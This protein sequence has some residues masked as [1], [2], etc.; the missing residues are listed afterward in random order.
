MTSIYFAMH[1][2]LHIFADTTSARTRFSLSR[3][4]VH[5]LA[6]AFVLLAAMVA[7]APNRIY[8]ENKV[9][10]QFN[11]S[12]TFPSNKVYTVLSGRK[13]QMYANTSDNKLVDVDKNNTSITTT[14]YY[15]FVFVQGTG[16]N[17]SNYYLYN[18]GREQFATDVISNNSKST[19]YLR[20]NDVNPIYVWGN[21]NTD[22]TYPYVLSF[23][24]NIDGNTQITIDK[25]NNTN[26]LFEIY[27]NG[28]WTTDW[29]NIQPHYCEA[30]TE[31]P[32][33]TFTDAELTAAQQFLSGSYNSTTF[34][35]QSS[36]ITLNT[37]VYTIQSEDGYFLVAT[38]TGFSWPTTAPTD[39]SGQFVFFQNPNNT[40]DV[41]LYSVGQKKFVSISGSTLGEFSASDKLHLFTTADA[42]G[43]GFAF[44]TSDTWTGGS[45]LTASNGSTIILSTTT[46]PA[47]ANRFKLNAVASTATSYDKSAAQTAF[48]NYF[49]EYNRTYYKGQDITTSKGATTDGK[50][51]TLKNKDDKYLSASSSGLTTSATATTSNEQFLFFQNPAAADGTEEVYL[52]S[53][54]QQ[55]FVTSAGAPTATTNA[56]GTGNQLF[57]YTASGATTSDNKPYLA[58]AF[59]SDWD[60]ATKLGSTLNLDYRF[61]VKEVAASALSTTMEN[62]TGFAKVVYTGAYELSSLEEMGL[63]SKK[64]YY[65]YNGDYSVMANNGNALDRYSRTSSNYN[66]ETNTVATYFAFVT[67]AFNTDKLY[68]YHISTRKAANKS[69]KLVV[70]SENVNQ[71]YIY[72]T[73][74]PDFPFALSF[75]PE[76]N[77]TDAV[78]IQA[79]S[80]N[81]DISND[82]VPSIHNRLNYIEISYTN[83]TE[84]YARNILFG[85]SLKTTLSDI[86]R[87]YDGVY[88][89][90]GARAALR[91]DDAETKLITASN[92][93]NTDGPLLTDSTNK[94]HQFVFFPDHDDD[95]KVYLYN[96]QAEKFVNKSGNLST[97]EP[98][99]IYIFYTN[100]STYPY[101]FSF[102][103]SPT[104]G[105]TSISQYTDNYVIN[106][107]QS[108]GININYHSAY[109]A[110]NCF[111]INK[112]YGAYYNKNF[113]QKIL[114]DSYGDPVDFSTL[115][116][117]TNSV[118][119][120]LK[121][122]NGAYLSASG[123]SVAS[124]STT[125]T[126]SDAN[127]QFVFYKDPSNESIIYLYSVGRG[128]FVA[129]DGTYSSTPAALTFYQTSD[130][131]SYS[132]A[133]GLNSTWTTSVVGNS[134]VSVIKSTRFQAEKVETPSEQWEENEPATLLSG[135]YQRATLA[136]ANISVNK[137]YIITSD[138]NNSGYH[139][140]LDGS[141]TSM[142]GY[143][144]QNE[145]LLED[146][147][148]QP[149][150]KFAFV[151]DPQDESK[152]YLL[153]YVSGKAIDKDGNFTNDKSA[154]VTYQQ[155]YLYATNNYKY[156]LAFSFSPTWG[157]TDAVYLD[158]NYNGF[159]A[160]KLVSTDASIGSPK[161]FRIEEVDDATTYNLTLGRAALKGWMTTEFH[162]EGVQRTGL[163]HKKETEP[164]TRYQDASEVH[165][166]YYVD[167][168]RS[169]YNDGTK[170]VEKTLIFTI[171]TQNY[172]VGG[173]NLEPRGYFR[174]YDYRTDSIVPGGNLTAY[175]TG[176]SVKYDIN[177]RPLGYFST[178]N[179]NNPNIKTIGVYY[180]IPDSADYEN[181][182]GDIIA[183]DVSRYIDYNTVKD[184]D[185]NIAVHS[186]NFEHEPTL[187]IRYIYH[188]LPAK[189]LA[190]ELMDKLLTT[191][192]GHADTRWNKG[193]LLFGA[194]DGNSTMNLRADL[195]SL[196]RY[197][198]YPLTSDAY[199]TKHVYYN[200]TGHEFLDADF[201]T[202]EP[203]NATGVEWRVYN[204]DKSYYRT[205]Y[206]GSDLS[207]NIRVNSGNG[208][209]IDVETRGL[210]G[211]GWTKVDDS[212]TGTI[213]DNPITIGSTCYIVGYLTNGNNKCPF[214]NTR[215]DITDNNP[216]SSDQIISGNLTDRTES[217]FT[218][219]YGTTVANFQF[220]DENS[221]LTGIYPADQSDED[222]ISPIPSPFSW[223]QYS[224]VYYKLREFSKL[225]YHLAWTGLDEVKRNYYPL[226]GDFALYKR[227]GATQHD[228]TYYKS[229]G[230]QNGYFLFTDASDE[231]RVIATQDFQ[232]KFCTGS[233]LLITAWVSNN[234]A[235]RGS[236]G[237]LY[238]PPELR[239]NLLGVKKDDQNED[240]STTQLV[241]ICSG[242]F[243]NNIDDYSS[244]ETGTW[245]QVYGVLTIPAELNVSQFT[246]FRIAI[247]N[248]CGGATGADYAIDDIEVYQQNAKLTVIQI[249]AL[250]DD[251]TNTNEVKIK[252]KGNFDALRSVTNTNTEMGEQTVFYRFC[253]T[254]GQAVTGLDYDGD[255]KADEYGSATVPVAYSADAAQV[256]GTARFEKGIDGQWDLVLVNR[257]FTLD[258]STTYYVSLCLDAP[259]YDSNGNITAHK[260]SDDWGT[261][262][263]VC[264]TYSSNFQ[265]VEQQIQIAGTSGNSTSVSVPCGSST[266]TAYNGIAVTL[267]APDKVNGGQTILSGD[268]LKFFWFAGTKEEYNNLKETINETDVYLKNAVTAYMTAYPDQ[269]FSSDSVAKGA[270]TDAE[271]ALLEKY[272]CVPGDLN[273]T[274]TPTV[275]STYTSAN[276]SAAASAI[277][278]YTGTAYTP[279]SETYTAGTST[280]NGY[281][282]TTTI[283]Y[284]SEH[285]T[286]T[287]VK[288]T[289]LSTK[290]DGTTYWQRKDSIVATTTSATVDGV[291]TD[292]YTVTK[293]TIA[294][295]YASATN[296]LSDYPISQGT[297][298]FSAIPV[299]TTFTASNGQDYT[300]CDQPMVIT[301]RGMQTGPGLT[302]GLENVVYPAS[303]TYRSVR[304]G[305]PQIKAM[306]SNGILNVPI[307][308]RLWHADAGYEIVDT[309]LLQFTDGA[310][311]ASGD[312]IGSDKLYI[313]NT[314][315]PSIDL[316]DTENDKLLFATI[317][318]LATV[319]DT[320][321][322]LPKGQDVLSLQFNSKMVA[323]LHEGYWYEVA[324]LF[325]RSDLPKNDQGGTICA[326]ETF[327]TFKIVPEY[328]TWEPSN[329]TGY[330]SN[331]NRDDNWRRSTAAELYSL[332][333]T[334]YRSS[335][336][337]ADLYSDNPKDNR[338]AA[339]TVSSR[340]DAALATTTTQ[341][342]TYVPMYFS[343]VTIPTRTTG[344]YPM[345]PYVLK[346][347]YGLI[348]RMQNDKG[349]RP[350]NNIQY[351]MMAA[352][353]A[354]ASSGQTDSTY[355]C[356]NF[357][358][359][360]CQQILFKP[361]GQL[362]KQQF[363]RYQKAW[364]ERHV[365]INTWSTFTTLMKQTPS[366]DLYVPKF[367]AQQTTPSFDE[368]RFTDTDN[369]YVGTDNYVT[370]DAT[371]S[372][373]TAYGLYGKPNAKPRY[374]RLR[375]PVYQRLWGQ[376]TATEYTETGDY[377]AYDK[378]GVM[379]IDDTQDNDLDSL[380]NNVS[381]NAWSHPFN[382][383]VDSGTS[384]TINQGLGTNVNGMGMAVKVGDE[385]STPSDKWKDKMVLLRLPKSDDS[386]DFYKWTGLQEEKSSLQKY[387]LDDNAK[388]N[389]Y[390]L[391]I[392]YSIDE[393]NL[394]T[395]T[396]TTPE[397]HPNADEVGED[398]SPL[399]YVLVGNPY[400]SSILVDEFI[401]ANRTVMQTVE[402]TDNSI[403][404]TTSNVYC[405]WVLEGNVLKEYQY[406]KGSMIDAGEAFFV[407]VNNPGSDKV[408]FTT[409][410]QTDPRMSTTSATRVAASTPSRVYTVE[411]P[412]DVKTVI[413]SRTEPLLCTSPQTGYL[414]VQSGKALT[415]VMV[416][417]ANGMLVANHK[418]ADACDDQFFVGSGIA[419]VRA[420]ATDGS[421]QTVKIV[422][423]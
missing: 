183:C 56:G 239:F 164:Y 97:G 311:D 261:P 416:Y 301:V 127:A 146:Y 7:F 360:I 368:I 2:I 359:N 348:L 116:L 370:T 390:R 214:F 283:D 279:V 313:V 98:D 358:G 16:D 165:Y 338:T 18:V 117:T 352:Y 230:S 392:D 220:D 235:Y 266:A 90:Y 213:G 228:R 11:I 118:V 414:R 290:N 194:K 386:F 316:N 12:T 64:V 295:L 328:L 167:T 278:N 155:I 300:I 211:D 375:M 209:L 84:P 81:Q 274:Y 409:R 288:A 238:W 405:V 80:K 4:A 336:Y 52:Y 73:Y 292:T 186:S 76:W 173:H 264:S 406:G 285:R 190:K 296:S 244:H 363:L 181:W 35:A 394:G 412:T 397:V 218:T 246:D 68:L 95:T 324:I 178:N 179:S 72:K 276:G 307:Q 415:R 50:V 262:N 151:T 144:R 23:S 174:W 315:D 289:N 106:G 304:I 255:G 326:G 258:K 40:S 212:E 407:K 75:S 293:S 245:Y 115:G 281:T 367:T 71:I 129:S 236:D 204:S 260:P 38:K 376:N 337:S 383:M 63:S 180:T 24:G 198:F 206:S 373:I 219:N 131:D 330:N 100:N 197:Y 156:P 5:A 391:G 176:L 141:G 263:N 139:V 419:I 318:N 355:T 306:G 319:N 103:E 314:N 31:V 10:T 388:A 369:V 28:V 309:E 48:T 86:G 411:N 384:S 387:E 187:S 265:L 78:C 170:D 217:Y 366:G 421:V 208:S 221:Q 257:G 413:S 137:L 162:Y 145:T 202:S 59:G 284:N 282:V 254:D 354:T 403:T 256:N 280:E 26:R 154:S 321:F 297:H 169:E 192:G 171:P 249:P 51:Y 393:N 395:L 89:I 333:Y 94:A 200:K 329:T 8:A 135:K 119:Y 87:S 320:A 147:K 334:D 299:V 193:V 248:Y 99:P 339:K 303:E 286:I 39:A 143:S 91:V 361:G 172:L 61:E 184:A 42:H 37:A 423:R 233:K 123:N 252:I 389:R 224:F 149:G 240:I 104:F 277:I 128:A 323:R 17:S 43:Y 312:Y 231:A 9:T 30:I 157:E 159:T 32:D 268:R 191:V 45:V 27:T 201:I 317:H 41:Y 189:K 362:R 327:L 66:K 70:G 234:T 365:P 351:D 1:N 349:E 60:S 168:S 114:D 345:M 308:H 101:L 325:V 22:Q 229:N 379:L 133:I 160:Q 341:P 136:E 195:Q 223:R 19:V 161:R 291:T 82:V 385:F 130:P 377:G 140:L 381:R 77:A 125:T 335:T 401:D 342:H 422:V 287:V 356:A 205:F 364:V 396:L 417:H 298:S 53:V 150:V 332:T 400:T 343:K 242:Q 347:Q 374:S 241:S 250:C 182:T 121:N 67:D 142:N 408:T 111:L 120:N 153:N 138:A 267:T 113:V 340:V 382:A 44:G 102:N 331:W 105:N 378:P 124:T 175:G 199:Q 122:E 243:L 294:P 13:W 148:A 402:R 79:N 29:N 302:L 55:K 372:G 107:G 36:T 54:G 20:N 58:F 216:K 210:N 112:V 404:S 272:A 398:G 83:F 207:V 380:E 108:N 46:A 93:N 69:G 346:N 34:A 96:I 410:M 196:E 21:D 14:P 275:A 305:L 134:T 226:H 152:I 259:T 166:Y 126:T 85:T 310:T 227:L 344:V 225:G 253:T 353:D 15:Q 88:T 420:I 270:Y 188:I 74:D 62:T 33:V 110:G 6:R 158:A 271:K 399:T 273:Q 251:N 232:G 322:V 350:T 25:R 92:K 357:D 109:D 215:L 222:N 247:D 3:P 57:V 203:V 65:L 237:N 177:G 163:V 371:Q 132:F 49:I 185:G 418:M 269:V 47:K